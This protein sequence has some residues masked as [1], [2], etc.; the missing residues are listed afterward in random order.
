M[1]KIL[2]IYYL[3]KNT[4]MKKILLLSIIFVIGNTSYSQNDS[5]LEAYHPKYKELIIK[6]LNYP[7][8][9]VK[10]GFQGKTQVSFNVHIDGSTSDF[11]VIQGV[12]NCPECDQ[13]AI[14][15]LK[16]MKK[17]K[18][19]TVNGKAIES[20]KESTIKFVLD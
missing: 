17:W 13:E 12:P 5:L 4:P 2:K 3:K 18:P 10:K 11:K 7:P 1:N 15:V 19:A 8:E 20:R 9:A 14:R 16:L 6:H